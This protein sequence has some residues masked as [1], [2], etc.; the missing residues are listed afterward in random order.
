VPVLC[1]RLEL[2]RYSSVPDF[3][4]FTTDQEAPGFNV[5][6]RVH[7][8][9]WALNWFFFLFV[10]VRIPFTALVE[11]KE[12]MRYSYGS[13]IARKSFVQSRQSGD[14]TDQSVIQV[15]LTKLAI[16]CTWFWMLRRLHM[17]L[18]TDSL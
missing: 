7:A 6:T 1:S 11:P 2:L 16:N 8:C 17:P 4:C 3:S 9:P 14:V 10:Y 12:G 15:P 18:C 5:R 13:L